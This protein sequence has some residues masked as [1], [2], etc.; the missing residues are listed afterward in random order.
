MHPLVSVIIA[1]Y[2]G[3]KYLSEAIESVL[4]QSYIESASTR[5]EL[6]IIDDGSRD[7]TALIAEKYSSKIR[8]V[9]QPNQGQP[10][11]INLGISLAN[12]EYIAFLDADDLYLPDKIALQVELLRDEPQIDAVYGHVQQFISPELPLEIRGKWRCPPEIAPGFLAG[13]GLF[14][15]ELFERVGVFAAQRNIGSFIDWYMRATEK[16]VKNKLIENLVMRR[17]IHGNNI[18]VSSLNP[19]LEYLKIVKAALERRRLN[20]LA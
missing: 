17:R 9:Y 12:G 7:Q 1:V 5:I 11:A 20:E 8:Y 6:I 18:G 19:R 13:A 10:T 3:E 4:A 14:R 15:R 16:G 2:N